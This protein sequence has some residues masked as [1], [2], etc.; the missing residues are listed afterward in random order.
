MSIFHKFVKFIVLCL[1][2]RVCFFN[3]LL[4]LLSLLTTTGRRAMKKLTPKEMKQVKG[5]KI[6]R[7]W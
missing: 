7:R 3:L 2:F 1:Q 6:V 4:K 5:G